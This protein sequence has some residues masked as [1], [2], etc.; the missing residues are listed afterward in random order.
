MQCA[1]R[2]I[3]ER[4][5]LYPSL[6]GRMTSFNLSRWEER[7]SNTGCLM[8]IHFGG[9]MRRPPVGPMTAALA[10]TC[11]VDPLTVDYGRSFL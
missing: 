2:R 5:T 10:F 8:T 1:L 6:G 9:G 4:L 3:A 7:S 11:V